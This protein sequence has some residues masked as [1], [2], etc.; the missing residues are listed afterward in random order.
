[1][2]KIKILIV[3]DQTLMREGLKTILSLEE[4]MEVVGLAEN[5]TKAIE[6]SKKLMPDVILMDIRMPGMNG[7]E[8][9]KEIK[10][11]SPNIKII[12]LTTFDDD[13]FIIDA[14]SHGASAYFLKDLPSDSLISSI[15]DAHKGVVLM[16]PEIVAKL[17]NNINSKDIVSNSYE[18]EYQVLNKMTKREGEIY[19][20]IK[21][22]F[23][24][25]E[26]AAKLF[27][28]EGTVKNYVSVIYDKLD[29][30][31]RTKAIFKSK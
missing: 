6:L 8:S 16:Q 31:D 1:M 12:I 30:K 3:D 15:R 17:V 22:G 28:T 9:T 20:L 21:E 5:G 23:S 29:V 27:I 7:V 4:D 26:I 11:S 24:N 13:E 10:R 18:E 14:L 2:N 19:L 25:K